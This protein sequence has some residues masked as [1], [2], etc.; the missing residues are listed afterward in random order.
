M[1]PFKYG[2]LYRSYDLVRSFIRYRKTRNLIKDV[3]YGDDFKYV[4][5]TYLNLELDKDWIGRLYGVI[6]PNVDISGNLDVRN[7]IIE[8]DSDNTNTDEYVKTWIYKQLNMMGQLFHMR[9]LY[10]YISMEIEPIG[11]I[12]SDN[13]LVVFDIA[14]REAMG[15]SFK[16]WIKT[17]SVY[18]VIGI[19]V[20]C[21]LFAL[22]II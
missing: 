13:Y 21:T 5:Q 12:G 14:D 16:K 22:H 9:S 4:V 18:S 6:N 19:S 2:I 1:N 3:F 15:S 20:L 7:V 17:A 11:P 10:S 8:I